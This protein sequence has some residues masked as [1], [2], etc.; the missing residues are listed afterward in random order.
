MGHARARPRDTC[1]HGPA[2]LGL[3]QPG[4]GG[5]RR[6]GGQHDAVVPGGARL[7]W[8]GRRCDVVVVATVGELGVVGLREGAGWPSSAV[9]EGQEGASVGV[10]PGVQWAYGRSTLSRYDSCHPRTF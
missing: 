3:G 9:E 6:R 4:V 2:C 8:R 7:R 5:E 10:S 1:M